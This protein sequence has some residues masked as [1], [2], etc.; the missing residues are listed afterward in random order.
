MRQ[1]SG[2]TVMELTIALMILG[3]VTLLGIK[4]YQG[5]QME[6]M[7]EIV[8]TEMFKVHLGLQ[9]E[10]EMTGAVTWNQFFTARGWTNPQDITAFYR[11][12]LGTALSAGRVACGTGLDCLQLTLSGIRNNQIATRALNR[13]GPATNCN[14]IGGT[15]LRCTFNRRF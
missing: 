1:N 9:Q 15:T 5:Y 2:F 13:I 11:P 14:I 3:I 7:A 4:G 12:Q 6:N 10:M 8:A